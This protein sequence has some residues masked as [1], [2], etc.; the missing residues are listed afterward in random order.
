MPSAPG[1]IRSSREQMLLRQVF[2][3]FH[4]MNDEMT[5]RVIARGFPLQPSW[6]P[7]LAYVDTEHGSRVNVLAR[8]LGV[9][10]QA[11]SQLLDEIEARGCVKRH[12]DPDD[13]RAVRVRFTAKG[14]RMLAAGMEVMRELEAE[15][16]AVIGAAELQRIKGKLGLLLAEID[17][18]GAL[19]TDQPAAAGALASSR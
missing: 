11:V 1:E 5:R 18:A 10:R 6:P 3:L 15:Y 13:G 8:S 2:R 7:L 17:P 14:R 9:S 12:A 19:G 4:T 16:A